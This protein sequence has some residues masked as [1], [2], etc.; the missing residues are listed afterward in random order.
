MEE[1]VSSCHQCASLKS[2]PLSSV[3]QSSENPSCAIGLSFAADVVKR[4][5]QLIF[6]LRECTSSY[7]V[8]L[9]ITDE[10]KATLRDA[11]LKTCLPIR[12]LTGPPAVIRTDPAPGF[13]S[14]NNDEILRQHHIVIEVGRVKNPN[15][16]PVAEKAV[17]ELERRAV[18]H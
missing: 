16:N 1:I 10:Q 4:N 8:S 5:R 2:T 18:N 13:A 14:L 12:P 6:I 3:K 7:T 15:K 9:L 17:L 11:I